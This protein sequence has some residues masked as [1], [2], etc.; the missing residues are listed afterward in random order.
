MTT[1]V[2]NSNMTINNVVVTTSSRTFSLVYFYYFFHI[3]TT[4][5]TFAI[6]TAW[7]H[8]QQYHVTTQRRHDRPRHWKEHQYSYLSLSRTINE[9]SEYAT[10]HKQINS[11]IHVVVVGGGVGGLAIA[12]RIATAKQISG[13]DH[14][15]IRVT[16][17][18][19]NSET[20]G[21]CGSFDVTI[22]DPTLPT[23][24]N[25]KSKLVFRHERGPSLL[26]LP[27]MYQQLFTDVTVGQQV[28]QD[29]GL[30][31]KQCVP[32]YTVVFDDGDRINLGFPKESSDSPNNNVPSGS[33]HPE[34]T[35]SRNMMNQFETNG[36]QKWD[37]YMRLCRAYLECGLPNFIEER[38]DLNSFPNFVV[39]GGV[40]RNFG[41]SFPLKSHRDVLDTYFTSEK[42]CALA[43]FQDLYVG[44]QPFRSNTIGGGVGQST[45]PAVFGLLSAIELHP[46]VGGVYAPIGGFRAV[47]ESLHRLA[48]SYSNVTIQKNSTVVRVTNDG[49][50]YYNTTQGQDTDPPAVLQFLKADVIVINADLP[51]AEQS[52]FSKQQDEKSTEFHMHQ[53]EG[54]TPLSTERRMDEPRVSLPENDELLKMTYDWDECYQFSSG[55]IAF[56]WS[57]NKS[58]DELNT[59][60]VFLS[61]SNRTDA[62]QSWN[63]V[64]NVSLSTSSMMT[65]INEPFNFY[66]HRASK[67]DSTAAPSV[68]LFRLPLSFDYNSFI[69]ETTNKINFV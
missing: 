51:Y 37:D 44:L 21:R 3:V 13:K 5:S 8:I 61:A 32:A 12:S 29:F 42:M 31:I 34:Y 9:L 19:K 38:L 68:S 26:L 66:V 53:Q 54:S 45:A 7:N 17:L 59:H 11:P 60:N 58:L 41:Q 27:Q 49:V 6:V 47:Q 33:I 15:P 24:E 20:G 46:D 16:L 30:Y 35:E 43:S 28:A 63:Y 65:N 14:V 25:E 64:R 10:E 23:V 69:A 62:Y 4:V 36:A 55:V 52:L 67:T 22:P 2:W 57:I 48:I 50:Y 18:E 1:L 39:E 40:L 56:H